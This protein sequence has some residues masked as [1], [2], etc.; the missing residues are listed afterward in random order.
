MSTSQLTREG[1]ARAKAR[2]V[3]LGNGN[4]ESARHAG[5]VNVAKA[6]EFVASYAWLF[7]LWRETGETLQ[8]IA[9]G[10]NAMGWITRRNGR[11]SNV[12]IH[13]ILYGNTPR[14]R[15]RQSDCEIPPGAP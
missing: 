8:S 5:A 11:W 2:G 13:R 14:K 12:A 4:R 1:L 15:T 9:D 3:K 7:R 6:Q 10:L